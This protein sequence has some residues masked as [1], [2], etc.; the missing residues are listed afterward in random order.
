MTVTSFLTS[1]RAA[2]A[3]DPQA[4]ICAFYL[5]TVKGVADPHALCL[6]YR[7]DE[8]EVGTYRMFYYRMPDGVLEI[9]VRPDGKGGYARQVTDFITDPKEVA[10][11]LGGMAGSR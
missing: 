3:T 9:E 2:S 10:S 8:D 11:M 5:I 7:E 4:Q 1:L 6:G